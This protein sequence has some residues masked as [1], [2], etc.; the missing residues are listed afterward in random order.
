MMR[1]NT[2]ECHQSHTNESHISSATVPSS[3]SATKL[4]LPPTVYLPNA[5]DDI[6]PADFSLDSLTDKLISLMDNDQSSTS[7]H[8]ILL[9][10]TTPQPKMM[11]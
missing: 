1:R 5:V 3:S 9:Y 2:A 8:D 7:D 11:D 6:E 10:T 4:P